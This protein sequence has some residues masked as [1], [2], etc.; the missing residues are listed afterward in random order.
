MMGLEPSAPTRVRSD[1]G[2]TT[3]TAIAPGDRSAD[4]YLTDEVFLY[5]LI[6]GSC[7]PRDGSVELEDCF[8]LDVVR[9]PLQELRQRSLRVV[10]PAL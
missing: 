10:M 5:R 9:V 3:P 1:L 7:L 6:S 4:V 2:G 8:Q